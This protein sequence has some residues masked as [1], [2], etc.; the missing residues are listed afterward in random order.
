MQ[1]GAM[2]KTAASP[3]KNTVSQSFLALR[4]A[5]VLAMI[6]DALT[7]LAPTRRYLSEHCD[8]C[9]P[10][11]FL[12]WVCTFNREEVAF[13]RPTACAFLFGEA[14]QIQSGVLMQAACR[15][16]WHQP[17]SSSLSRESEF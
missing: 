15:S 13:D 8:S 16:T 5:S 7:A 9:K 2:L 14:S 4:G 12:G 11:M 17:S 3:S 6:F 10:S 1:H